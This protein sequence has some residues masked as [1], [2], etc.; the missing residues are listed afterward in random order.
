MWKQTGSPVYRVRITAPAKINL[1]L[2]ILRR[3]D[4]GYHEIATVMAM[5]DLCDVVE[6]SHGIAGQI[7]RAKIIKGI[8]R[9]DDLT[10]QAVWRIL[11]QKNRSWEGASVGLEKHIP[12]AAGLGG[13]SSDAAATLIAASH[14]WARHIDQE[15]LLQEAA[16]IG[17]D[18]PFFL[19]TPCALATGTGTTLEPLPPPSG[20]LLIV[21]PH[22][23]IENKT[24]TMY[25]ALTPADFS[26]GARVAD[27]ARRLRAGQLPDPRD[28]HNAFTRPLYAI[29]PDLARLPRIICDH[30]AKFAALSGAGPS[31][32]TWFRTS[33]AARS[34]AGQ[35]ASSLPE[36]TRMF[37]APFTSL[38]LADRLTI[39]M[40]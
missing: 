30:G 10:L 21:T 15:V 1:G 11:M 12:I 2:E 32:Y 16:R 23:A 7:R 27:V 29:A 26:D 31:H 36:E 33:V 24:A 3:R 17:S 6:V 8:R 40:T 22:L 19:G 35:M 34:A 20:W 4:D 39:T 38:R 37:V 28:L 5:V 13:A 9:E 14:F 25:G 18:V